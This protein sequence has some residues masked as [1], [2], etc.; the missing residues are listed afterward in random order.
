MGKF[1]SENANYLATSAVIAA[2]EGIL[3]GFYP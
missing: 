1:G 2:F 3:P